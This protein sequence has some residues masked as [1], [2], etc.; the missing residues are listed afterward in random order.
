MYKDISV[1][2]IKVN[3]VFHI[4]LYMVTIPVYHDIQYTVHIQKL[5]IWDRIRSRKIIP[6]HLLGPWRGKPTHAR[7]F[8]NCTLVYMEA[9]AYSCIEVHICI[10]VVYSTAPRVFTQSLRPAKVAMLTQQMNGIKTYADGH[11]LNKN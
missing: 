6:H 7:A 2:G 3:K 4:V 9:Q 8:V 10:V 5:A 11:L 1:Y